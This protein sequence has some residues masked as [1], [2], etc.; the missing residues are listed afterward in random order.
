MNAEFRDKLKEKYI[1]QILANPVYPADSSIIQ[2]LRTALFQLPLGDLGGLA[3]VID[4][5]RESTELPAV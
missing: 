4:L 3:Y 2:S 5:K 1:G